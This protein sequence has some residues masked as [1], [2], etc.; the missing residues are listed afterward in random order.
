MTLED[1]Y[2]QYGKK[3]HKQKIICH[4]GAKGNE[5][6]LILEGKVT[7]YKQGPPPTCDRIDI[8]RLEKDNFFGEMT[9]LE[10]FPRTASVQALT[11][12]RLLVINLDMLEKLFKVRPVFAIQMFKKFSERLRKSECWL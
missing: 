7:V 12:V 1:L 8:A 11:E 2:Q 3:Y 6:Y 5:M 9:L 10:G 4:E